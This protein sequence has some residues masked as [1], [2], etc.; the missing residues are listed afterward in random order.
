MPNPRGLLSARVPSLAI[1]TANREVRAAI[2]EQ[3]KKK[4]KKRGPYTVFTA[5]E[6]ARIGKYALDHGVT[7]ARRWYM[8]QKQTKIGESTIRVFMQRYRQERSKDPNVS[9]SALRLK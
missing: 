3:R 2:E 4:S 1:S 9:V 5:Q 7:A 8:A 6:R